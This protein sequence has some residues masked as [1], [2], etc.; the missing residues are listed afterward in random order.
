M[1]ADAKEEIEFLKLQIEAEQYAIDHCLL[2]VEH[3]QT[4]ADQSANRLKRYKER[5]A[6][7][8]SQVRA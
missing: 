1:S 3:Y 2:R 7:E 5:L 4:R 6:A 8:L